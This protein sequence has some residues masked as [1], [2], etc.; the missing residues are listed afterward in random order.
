[1]ADFAN[2]VVTVSYQCGC[3]FTDD[4]ETG[5]G[6]RFRFGA[7][8]TRVF[9]AS[10]ELEGKP[11]A[12]RRAILNRELAEIKDTAGKPSRASLETKTPDE[13]RAALLERQA[14][15]VKQ[16]VSAEG[17]RFPQPPALCPRHD[18]PAIHTH[19]SYLNPADAKPEEEA[20]RPGGSRGG[21][22]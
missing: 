2:P 5:G 11:L 4:T 15:E 21:G 22:R 19:A 18:Q 16:T 12:A 17:V 13:V 8:E 1:M 9:R 7:D 20:D 10:R 6:A 14:T 3:S